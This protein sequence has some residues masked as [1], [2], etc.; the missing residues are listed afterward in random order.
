MAKFTRESVKAFQEKLGIIDE[1]WQQEMNLR[2][3]VLLAFEDIKRA[4]QFKATWKQIAD[5]LIEVSETQ[6]SISPESIR[7]YYFDISNHPE[8]LAQQKRAIKK[9]SRQPKASPSS[10]TRPRIETE[11]NSKI[12]N[13]RDDISEQFNLSRLAHSG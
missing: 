7:Q 12:D 4:R 1:T 6:E 10:T 3:T 9:S 5:I 2:E 13:D 11:K 8:Q